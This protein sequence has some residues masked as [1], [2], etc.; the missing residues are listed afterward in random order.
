MQAPGDCTV[1]STTTGALTMPDLVD[2]QLLGLPQGARLIVCLLL[3]EEAD[4]A[5]AVH[6]VLAGGGFL[7]RH[8]RLVRGKGLRI[9]EGLGCSGKR[10]EHHG[11]VELCFLL[12]LRLVRGKGTCAGAKSVC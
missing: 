5:A 1:A 11:H 6:E 7:R 12:N 4:V 3:E 10:V 2:G 9:A 8:L